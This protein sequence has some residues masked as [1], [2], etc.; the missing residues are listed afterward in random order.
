MPKRESLQTD[1]A[2]I[3]GG[4]LVIAI[5]LLIARNDIPYPS[6]DPRSQPWFGQIVEIVAVALGLFVF[7]VGLIRLVIALRDRGA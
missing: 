1:I 3:I 4:P 5:G 2:L 7:T 6:N